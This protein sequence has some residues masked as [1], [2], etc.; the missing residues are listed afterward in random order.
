M[1]AGV[2]VCARLPSIMGVTVLTPS[3]VTA[4]I[5]HDKAQYHKFMSANFP[6]MYPAADGED[7]PWIC[8]T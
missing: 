7:F 4:D 1:D 2:P 5:C 8:K 3:V 6:L